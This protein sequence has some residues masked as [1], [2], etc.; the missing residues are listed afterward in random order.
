M[1][2]PDQ[3]RMQVQHSLTSL[4]LE[5]TPPGT[6]IPG[7]IHIASTPSQGDATPSGATVAT[8]SSGATFATASHAKVSSL[9]F[10]PNHDYSLTQVCQYLSI[11][12]RVTV[13]DI[14]EWS[15]YVPSLYSIYVPSLYSVG[16][17]VASG[18]VASGCVAVLSIRLCGCA[19]YSYSIWFACAL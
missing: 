1:C 16:G 2:Q 10:T 8:A 15:L 17:Y 3:D 19:L 13:R 6:S 7:C 5:M 4:S 12:A 18:H 14:R 9:D 11:R